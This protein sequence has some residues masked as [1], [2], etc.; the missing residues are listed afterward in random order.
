MVWV[1]RFDPRCRVPTTPAPRSSSDDS[2]AAQRPGVV[3]RVVERLFSTPGILAFLAAAVLLPGG[4][5]A[6]LVASAYDA[7]TTGVVVE[8]TDDSRQDCNARVGFEVD[9]QEYEAIGRGYCADDDGWAVGDDVAVYYDPTDPTD[10][11]TDA[12]PVVQGRVMIGLGILLLALGSWRVLV[13]RR[14]RG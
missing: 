6:L 1:R 5:G 9:G 13:A 4:V 7:S 3:A 2:A 8:H 14:R 12:G 10:N 11:G